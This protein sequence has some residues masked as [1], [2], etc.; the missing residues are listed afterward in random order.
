MGKKEL[1]LR[2]IFMKLERFTKDCFIIH[3]TAFIEGD[4]G[5]RVGTGRVFGYF[6]KEATDVLNT[7]YSNMDILKVSSIRGAKD[8]PDTNIHVLDERSGSISIE[9]DFEKRYEKLKGVEWS[10]FILSDEDSEKMFDKAERIDYEILDGYKI[11]IAKG[12]F[13]S[14]TAKRVSDIVYYAEVESNESYPGDMVHVYFK[15]DSDYF[16]VYLEYR[17]L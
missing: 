17:W 5:F 8:E 16:T 7:T 6:T 2:D 9:S 4:E 3:N 11:Q 14:M 10:P 12:L 15:I 13:P 1:K